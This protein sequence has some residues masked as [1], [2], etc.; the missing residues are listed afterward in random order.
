MASTLSRQA[1]VSHRARVEDRLRACGAQLWPRTALWEY[2]NEQEKKVLGAHL[3]KF[4][5]GVLSYVSLRNTLVAGASAALLALVAS[6][7]AAEVIFGI[8]LGG[9]FLFHIWGVPAWHTNNLL[10]DDLYW[11]DGAKQR[12]PEPVQKVVDGVR[13]F[14]PNAY[15][16][17]SFLG[18]DPVLHVLLNGMSYAALVWDVNV[19]GTIDI[20][21][22]PTA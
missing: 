21:R 17:V 16:A 12:L 9:K 13:I 10:A 2:Q 18:C 3:A 5:R 8:Y 6:P 4:R 22:P 19:D 15:F 14:F 11:R 20:I 7:S 1:L